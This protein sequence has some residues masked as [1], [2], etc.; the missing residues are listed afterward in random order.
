MTQGQNLID[1]SDLASLLRLV[2]EQQR[3]IRDLI[4]DIT[5]DIDHLKEKSDNISVIKTKLES[6]EKNLNGCQSA[7]GDCQTRIERVFS[8]IIQ[9]REGLNQKIA[10]VELEL[11]KRIESNSRECANNLERV[12]SELENKHEK[13]SEIIFD[14]IKDLQQDVKKL[15]GEAGKYGGIIA[16]IVSI[17]M[18]LAKA[19]WDHTFKK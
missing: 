17:I 19:L 14:S 11:T 3:G 12:R 2:L 5:K 1:P 9:K 10:S 16:L 18:F 7:K 8:E 15:T 4:E 6:L 13:K